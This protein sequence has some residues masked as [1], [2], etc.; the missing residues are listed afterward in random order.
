MSASELY[1]ASYARKPVGRRG[2]GGA[3]SQGYCTPGDLQGS[4]H[5][6]ATQELA[7][8]AALASRASTGL[9]LDGAIN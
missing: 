3:E 4:Q 6:P 2:L 5:W 7:A 8:E 1:L 9:A